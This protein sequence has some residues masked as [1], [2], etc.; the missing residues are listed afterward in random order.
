[1]CKLPSSR[2]GY[3]ANTRFGVGINKQEGGRNSPTSYNRILSD[4]QFWDGRAASLEEQA[5]GPIQN[6]IEMGN[7]HEVAVKTISEIP[8]YVIQ[9]EK[10]F[11]GPVNIDN[12]AKAIASFER[13][14]VTG[15]SPFDYNEVL[16]AFKGEDEDDIKENPAA[17]AKYSA[18]KAALT[19]PR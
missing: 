3:A 16:V 15:P 18:A 5:K 17:W 2:H 7:T 1:M 4:L 14:V 10:V 9:F 19:R 6:P 11:G 8:G 13:A 12:I